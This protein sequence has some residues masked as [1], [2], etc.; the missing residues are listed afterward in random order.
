MNSQSNSQ[1]KNKLKSLILAG[2]RGKRLG[3]HTDEINK[4]LL[5]LG[6]KHLI[7]FSLDNAVAL[8]VQEIVIVVGYMSNRIMEAIG[9]SYKGIPV[10]YVLQL[11]QRGLVH[12]M[13]CSWEIVGDN[14]FILQLADEYF[15]DPQHW[16]LYRLYCQQKAF[17]VCGV[18][19]V[20][21]P[22]KI[23]KTY[24]VQID[25]TTKKIVRLVEKPTTF[26]NNLMGTGN[27]LFSKDIFRYISMTPTNL[28]RGE[29]ELPDLIQC[30]IDD[31]KTV[32]SF[33]LAS[34][35]FNVNTKI[36]FLALK[37]NYSS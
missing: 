10:K 13:E 35:Y 2:G 7:E 4:A 17:A 6:D 36:D 26:I 22:Q 5:V 24:S 25:D 1:Q 11:E 20:E 3:E 30:A 32:L 31:G 16:K 19:H 27:I 15:V 12:A 9:N 8:G 28:K 14:D 21:D 18:V 34:A 29:K 33:D 23:A 37:E